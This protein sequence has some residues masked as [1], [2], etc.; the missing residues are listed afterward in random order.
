MRP[1]WRGDL[2]GAGQILRTP[3]DAS[4]G[5]AAQQLGNLLAKRGDLDALRPGR[6]RPRVCRWVPKRSGWSG[7]A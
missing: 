1:A 3:A 4:D 6:R 2:D 7:S 5:Q